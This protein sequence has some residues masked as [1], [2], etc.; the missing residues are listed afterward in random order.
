MV[1]RA[2]GVDRQIE[3]AALCVGLFGAALVLEAMG[4]GLRE[5]WLDRRHLAV[6]L[7]GAV[8]WAGIAWAIHRR[9]RWAWTVT[10]FIG[11]PLFLLGGAHLLFVLLRGGAF[12]EG[13]G[14]AL[15]LGGFWLPLSLLSVA[16]MGAAVLCLSRRPVR[17]VFRGTGDA[18]RPDT[19]EKWRKI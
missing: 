6:H 12:V 15:R 1:G 17:E 3:F 4:V 18:T 14:Q 11:T 8:M 5:N 2:R 13:L 7:G 19:G 16:S 9:L 10:V